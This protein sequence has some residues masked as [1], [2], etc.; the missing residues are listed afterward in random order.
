ME[1]QE[2]RERWEREKKEIELKREEIR[3]REEREAR[4]KKKREEWE[5]ELKRNRELMKQQLMKKQH[6]STFTGVKNLVR[7]A[8]GQGKNMCQCDRMVIMHYSDSCI[9]CPQLPSLL[10]PLFLLVN[11]PNC[12]RLLKRLAV[13][14]N[15]GCIQLNL[16]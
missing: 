15:S 7:I 12:R 16:S 2:A 4:I 14:G 10:L 6:L 8:N 9:S 3:K 5:A 13:L 1:Q 11:H